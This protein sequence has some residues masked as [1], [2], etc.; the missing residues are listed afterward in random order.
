PFVAAPG[1]D[2]DAYAR[3]Y[4][5]ALRDG[6]K[7]PLMIWPFHAM[8]GGVGHALV[9][10]VEEAFFFHAIARA[11]PPRF[12]VKGRHALTENSSV[13]RPE[14]PADHEGR[15]LAEENQALVEWLRG[16]DA[17][18]VAGQARSHCVAWTVDDILAVLLARDPALLRRVYLLEDCS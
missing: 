10:A 7:Y 3:H 5:R 11:S 6:G 12:E 4:A 16:L 17:L 15:L 1:F 14:V 8:L 2:L 9:S 13:R 18:V